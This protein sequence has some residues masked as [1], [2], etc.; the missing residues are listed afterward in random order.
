MKVSNLRVGNIINT[1]KFHVKRLRGN[2]KYEAKWYK[3]VHMFMPVPLTE[4]LLLDLGIINNEIII[5]G[6]KV[7]VIVIDGGYALI[8]GLGDMYYSVKVDCKYVHTLQNLYFALTGKE[9][10]NK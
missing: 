9:L 2:Y 3:Y 6:D 10:E 8:G 7:I 5:T 1:G 4:Q